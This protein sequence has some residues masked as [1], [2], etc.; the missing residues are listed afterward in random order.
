MQLLD[1][2]VTETRLSVLLNV[3][4]VKLRVTSAEF[5]L[6]CLTNPDIRLELTKDGELIAMPPTGGETGKRNSKLNIRIGLWSEQTGLGE[7]FDSSTGYDFTAIGGGKISPDVSW[8]ETSRLEGVDISGF[9][10]IVPDFAVELRSK[11]DAIKD[12]RAK[13]EEYQRLGVR[14]GWLI[15]PQQQQVEIYRVN[16]DV[17][18]LKAPNTLNGEEVLPGLVL[19]LRSIL[20]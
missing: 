5:D 20:I 10:A 7:V 19:D 3:A 2:S 15:N 9:I 11:S 8:I 17:E 4:A 13:M 16:R 14:L 6:L 1:D 18:I 12:I